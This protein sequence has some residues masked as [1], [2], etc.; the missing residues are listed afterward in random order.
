MPPYRS[1]SIINIFLINCFL[2]HGAWY[3]IDIDIAKF[4]QRFLPKTSAILYVFLVLSRKPTLNL[5]RGVVKETVLWTLPGGVCLCL[6]PTESCS[7]TGT[8]LRSS[9]ASCQLL[10]SVR[11]DPTDPILTS[12]RA[13]RPQTPAWILTVCWSPA[14]SGLPK[15]L[16]Q[17]LTVWCS[18]RLISRADVSVLV[19]SSCER[20]GSQDTCVWVYFTNQLDGETP[21][22]ALWRRQLGIPSTA[23]RVVS[24]LKH[25]AGY[26]MTCR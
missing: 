8:P 6:G 13:A 10:V 18:E 26:M 15:G 5:I 2:F 12:L 22:T 1:C 3:C 23:A 4:C 20:S 24:D 11:A 9:R 7:P 19:F 17:V 21:P 16:P 25:G 14:W